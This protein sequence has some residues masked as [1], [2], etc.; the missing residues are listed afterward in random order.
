[1]WAWEPTA[2]RWTTWVDAESFS[3]N[4]TDPADLRRLWL[5]SPWPP[6]L[7]D[8]SDDLPPMPRVSTISSKSSSDRCFLPLKR[9]LMKNSFEGRFDLVSLCPCPSSMQYP[10]TRCRIMLAQAFSKSCWSRTFSSSA[11]FFSSSSW[12]CPSSSWLCPSSSW[13]CPFSSPSFISSKMLSAEKHWWKKR[14]HN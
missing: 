14:E 6:P 5:W 1:M 4:K 10:W 13:L 7:E 2:R 9:L 12:L 11:W 8:D 3:G